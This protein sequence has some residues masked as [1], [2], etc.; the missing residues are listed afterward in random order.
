M[1]LTSDCEC[2]ICCAF[3]QQVVFMHWLFSCTFFLDDVLTRG[4]SFARLGT[5]SVFLETQEAKLMPSHQWW[6]LYTEPCNPI[7]QR[8]RELTVNTCIVDLIYIKYLQR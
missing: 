5:S 8:R 3:G 4:D 7:Q 2:L 6:F 1:K